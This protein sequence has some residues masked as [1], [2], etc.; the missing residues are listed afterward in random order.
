MK[1]PS[2]M[3]KKFVTLWIGY[4]VTSIIALFAS[5]FIEANVFIP[6][7]EEWKN[8][9]TNNIGKITVCKMFISLKLFEESYLSQCTI[10]LMIW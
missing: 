10:Y 3:R 4:D 5:I 7:E 8:L 1:L 2:L 6:R 9:N